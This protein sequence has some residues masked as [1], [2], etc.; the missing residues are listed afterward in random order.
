MYGV[1]QLAH[2]HAH[3]PACVLPWTQAISAV[4]L[5]SQAYSLMSSVGRSVSQSVGLP[6]IYSL[7]PFPWPSIGAALGIPL[8]FIF[9]LMIHLK[10]VKDS[11]WM[12][13][14]LLP[15][16]PQHTPTIPYACTQNRARTQTD[17]HT[18][19]FSIHTTPHRS[20]AQHKLSKALDGV[21]RCANYINCSNHLRP[22]IICSL[23]LQRA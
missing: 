5:S 10:V 7:H 1:S 3:S 20:T 13:K 16:S 9:P 19:M 4:R 2:L 8:G 14:V 23:R 6:C 18:R 15:T 21:P 12:V 17:T 11:S 22:L